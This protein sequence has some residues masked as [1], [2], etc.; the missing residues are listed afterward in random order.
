MQILRSIG[1]AKLAT[2]IALVL[3][4]SIGATAQ[5][6]KPASLRSITVV[7]EPN[8]TVWIDGVRYG[9][10][11]ADGR[12]VIASV[13]PGVRNLRVRLNG[14]ADVTRSIPAATRGDVAVQLTKST[15]EAELALQAADR[16]VSVDREKAMGEYQRSI[17]LKANNP[18]A[19]I[20]LARAY[21]DRGDIENAFKAIQ[22]AK[23]LKPGNAEVSAIEGR[24]LK[25]TAE[26]EKA[27][28]TFKRSIAEGRGFQPEAY[29]GLGLL[30]KD[31]AENAGGSGDFPG[32]E[33]NYAEAAKYLAV[34][35]KQLGSAPDGIVVYQLLG[36]IY[37]RQKKFKEAI[38]LYEEF[39]R[40]FPDA[41][42][43]EAV[44]SFIVQ[45]KKQMAE[46]K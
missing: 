24:L 22:N 26:E 27:I 8:A 17:K 13:L 40:I 9:V 1:F 38:A 42:E 44:R 28:A 32:E 12:L 23:R 35:A 20:G 29:T 25:D 36:L 34:A 41:V 11:G 10:T 16:L 46:Q 39:L 30:F 33:A 37:E 5:G 4:V 3:L 18:G 7:T 31:R 19:Y 21:S 14:F 2:T 15:D 45:I 43:A 6:R